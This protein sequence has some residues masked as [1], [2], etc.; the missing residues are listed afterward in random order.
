MEIHKTQAGGTIWIM[1]EDETKFFR[2][3]FSDAP[4]QEVKFFN[5]PIGKRV[6]K[7]LSA[8]GLVHVFRASVG[9]FDE[10]LTSLRVHIE[11]G[12]EPTP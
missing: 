5:H 12:S 8:L 6:R 10:Y 3:V 4:G 9:E 1:S 7:I 2:E 11:S